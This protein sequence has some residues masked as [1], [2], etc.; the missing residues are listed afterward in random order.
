MTE[1]QWLSRVL[2]TACLHGWRC[3]HVRPARTAR[4]WRTPVQGHVG[5]P[6]LLLARD[7][8]LLVAELKSDRGRLGPGQREWLDAAGAHARLW[9]PQ[10]WAAVLAE[11]E[12]KGV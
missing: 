4:G 6:D 8:V 12:R 3:Q 1:E 11:L 9:K 5:A 7:G 10:D 2:E